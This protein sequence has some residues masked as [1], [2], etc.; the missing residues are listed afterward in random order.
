MKRALRREPVSVVGRR[1]GISEQTAL[2]PR[3]SWSEIRGANR[4]KT[5]SN[6]RPR[7]RRPGVISTPIEN[8][9]NVRC[10]IYLQKQHLRLV[11]VLLEHLLK[12]ILFYHRYN[13]FTDELTHAHTPKLCLER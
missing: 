1:H 4:P 5:F 3:N 6:Y 2:L 12:K 11:G 9:R 7:V 10:P 8:C 13:E